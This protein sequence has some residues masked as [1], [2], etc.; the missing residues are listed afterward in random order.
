MFYIKQNTSLT[1]CSSQLL[2][3]CD[4]D[5]KTLSWL[6]CDIEAGVSLDENLIR[7]S[8]NDIFQRLLAD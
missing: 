5:Q 1:E 8:L 6:L 4:K 2:T 7:D 3:G